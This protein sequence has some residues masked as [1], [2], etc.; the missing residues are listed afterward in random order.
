MLNYDTTPQISAAQHYG[1][2]IISLGAYSL[3]GD[4]T[5][6]DGHSGT[7]TP[8]ILYSLHSLRPHPHLHPS[9]GG[10]NMEKCIWK[11]MISQLWKD[12][13]QFLWCCFAAGSLRLFVTPWTAAHQV[14]L[15]STTSWSLLK[16]MSI[17]AVMVSNYLIL[18]CRHC[19]LIPV[20]PRITVFSNGFLYQMAKILAYQHQSFQ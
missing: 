2:H 18:C 11:F 20:L 17:E 1:S 7:Q 13:G 3:W 15:Y 8:P 4:C 5:P 10:K 9:A 6:S 14:L 19:L 16:Y 12:T